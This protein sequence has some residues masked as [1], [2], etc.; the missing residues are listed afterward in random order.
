MPF[1]PTAFR[2]AANESQGG[3]APPDGIYDA[4]VVS[5]EVAT[6]KS[7]GVQWA[8][9]TWKVL[10]G[11][12]RDSQWSTMWSLERFKADGERSG[13]FPIT[14]Q[15]LRTMGMDVER[16]FTPED[17]KRGLLALEGGV[18]SVGVKHNPPFVN[19]DVKQPLR[20][21]TPPPQASSGNAYG[22]PPASPP[23]GHT[24]PPPT[25]AIMGDDAG[26][27]SAPPQ[28]LAAS[29]AT[30]TDVQRT[31]ASDV[32]SPA[33]VAAFDR[34]NAP[35]RGSVDPETGEEIPF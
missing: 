9:I 12:H 20:D 24:A 29:A 5:A 15:Q 30:R 32:T 13:A 34:S 19:V 25:N 8:A 23:N 10:A 27:T 4:E 3:D 22:Q 31:G 6:R 17:L 21:A 7:D 28:S 1:D 11:P 16:V 14:V 35:Q 33:D 26:G 2:E 18:Y